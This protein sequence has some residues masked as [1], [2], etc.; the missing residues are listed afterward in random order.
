MADSSKTEKATQKKREDE[1]K[2]GNIFQSKDITNAIGFVITVFFLKLILPYIFAYTKHLIIDVINKIPYTDT[3]TITNANSILNDLI[4]SFVILAAPVGILAALSSILLAGIQTRFLF[5]AS[6]LKP[7]LSRLNPIAGLQKLFSVR[8]LV[9][10]MKSLVKVIII[11]SVFYSKLHSAVNE[12]LLTPTLALPDMIAFIGSKSYDIAMS[13]AIY[14]SLFAIADYMYQWWEYEKEIRM[15]KQEI[16]DEFKQTEGDPQ[17]K[18]RIRDVQRKMASIRMMVKVP[19]A[20]VVIKNP[21]HYA[22]ALQYKP[23]D[24]KAPIVVAK[25]KDY[26]ALKIIE[27]AEQNNVHITENRPLARGLYESAEIGMPIPE[28]FYKPIADILAY[29]YRL[30]KN[31][32]GKV[33]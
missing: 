33:S 14:I 31:K 2:K 26:V 27:I 6:K 25:G 4:I 15:T 23:P 20:D 32:S 5:S 1:R 8:S 29:I 18:S 17:I 7:Q 3:L 22:V 13:I 16:K 10:L 11:S 12:A 9:E 28:E 19:T 24:D 30:K 21:T